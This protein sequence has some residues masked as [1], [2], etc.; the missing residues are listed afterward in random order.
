MHFTCVGAGA[1][2]TLWALKLHAIGHHVHFWTRAKQSS[3]MCSF[4]FQSKYIFPANNTRI[5]AES[6]CILVCVKAFHVTTAL[7]NFLPYLHTS[8]L[9]ILMHNGM[10]T[11]KDA[12]R[13]LGDIPLL[14]ATTSQG[15]L[16]ISKNTIRHTGI[17]ETRLGGINASGKQCGFMANIFNDALAPCTWDTNIERAL[18]HKL[19][20]SCMINP[21]TGILQIQN[22]ELV[23]P[24]YRDQ[25]RQ[26]A[27][28]V[29]NVMRAKNI[30]IDSEIVLYHALFVAVAT[31]T[32]YSS[33]NR[34][35][36][37][38]RSSEIGFITGYLIRCAA[39]FGI[40]LPEN[41][42]LYNTIKHLEQ[43]Y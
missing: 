25:L 24:Q 4:E 14:L 9:V 19:A 2:G 35:I 38:K 27:N 6:D 20:I 16:L 5:L 23:L 33:M 1:I 37:F 41:Q 8:P 29:A 34:D 17:G 36:F 15:S 11:A 42:S 18:W 30:E 10:G 21:L 26:L 13:K 12:L 31:A 40:A 32:N 7:N 22:G 28:E 43:S 39:S 3:V